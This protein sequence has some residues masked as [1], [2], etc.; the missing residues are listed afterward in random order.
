[1]STFVLVHGAWHGAWCWERLTP[2][3]EALGH[4]VVAVDL[5]CDDPEATFEDYADVV[6]A[7]MDGGEIVV[8][9]SLAGNVLPLVAARRP[10]GRLVYLCAMVPDPGRSQAQQ[11]KAGDMTDPRYL[12]GL[13]RTDNAC[14]VWSEAELARAVLYGDCDDETAAAA[15]ARLR[16]Q[17]MSVARAVWTGDVRPAVPTTSIA[18]TDDAILYPA[19]SRRIA[20]DR[21][22][23]DHVELP[24]GH[25]PF[26]SRPAELA[27]VL[28]TLI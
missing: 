14:T 18:C 13:S 25:S 9:H 4:R 2:E 27:R 6:A 21:L 10:V 22:G 17:S 15:V 28:D 24:G 16:P 8:G 12:S 5:P 19:W 20:A 23:A 11:E 1:M 3:L 7:V 26:L